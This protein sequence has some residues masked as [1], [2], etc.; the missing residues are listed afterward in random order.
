[1]HFLE[2]WVA[3]PPLDL[4]RLA[5]PALLLLL[6]VFVPG[7]ALARLLT[8]G[9]A[10]SLPFLRELGASPGITTGWVLLWLAIAWQTGRR[11]RRTLRAGAG[12]GGLESGAVGL[13]LGPALL[14]LLLA[15]VAQ[16]DLDAGLTRRGSYGA[17][18]V[19]L[20]FL[21]LMLRRHAVRAAAAFAAMGLGL[22][23]LD[24]AVREVVVPGAA[25]PPGLPLL[26]SA[27]AAALAASVGRARISATGS[28]WVS[29]AH[30]LHD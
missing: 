28:A 3:L 27:L 11:S 29:D 14:A 21:H 19:G 10:V 25:P 12:L 30:D 18:L 22:Q 26:A 15:G 13:L 17:L 9:V 7:R 23:V 5:A 1:M 6:A 2:A 8:L 20:G 16:L 24:G 4:L